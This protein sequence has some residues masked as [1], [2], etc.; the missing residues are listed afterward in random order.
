MIY[1]NWSGT[2]Y[3]TEKMEK[4]FETGMKRQ[5]YD[6]YFRKKMINREIY[7]SKDVGFFE[8]ITLKERYCLFFNLL[9]VKEKLRKKTGAI[10]KREVAGL[11]NCLGTEGDKK[12]FVERF[13]TKKEEPKKEKEK[14]KLPYVT[15]I[16]ANKLALEL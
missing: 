15:N 10:S 7:F 5:D 2:A 9:K 14:I 8:I 4:I 1:I 11:I 6:Y 13:L 16:V 3:D 12:R